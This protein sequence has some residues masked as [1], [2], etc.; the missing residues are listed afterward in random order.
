M[1]QKELLSYAIVHSMVQYGCG[2]YHD[3]DIFPCVKVLTKE[4]S[5]N[6]WVGEN[7]TK[8][9]IIIHYKIYSR[10]EGGNLGWSEIQRNLVANRM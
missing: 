4:L 2:S 7:G 1:S 6:T 3:I 5:S 9:T 10:E 8:K